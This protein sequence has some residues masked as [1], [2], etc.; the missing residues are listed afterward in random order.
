MKYVLG[1]LLAVPVLFSSCSAWLDQVPENDIETIESIFETREQAHHWLY[2]VY[3]QIPLM[4]AFGGNP[5]FY[6]ADEFVM[7]TV[8][9]DDAVEGES[10]Y[11]GQKIAEGLQM[12]QDPYGDCW[13]EGS[14]SYCSLYEDIRNC[15]TFIENID[16]VYNMDEVEKLQWKGEIQALKAYCYFELMRRYGPIVLYPENIS[17]DA[18]ESEIYQ[19]RSHVD[20]CFKAIVDLLDEAAEHLLPSDARSF[21]RSA[22]F[23]KDAALA[24]KARVL[25]YAAS[26]LFNGNPDY[27]DFTGKDGE[28]LF[29]TEYDPEK[30]RLAAEAADAAVAFA[31]EHGHELFSGSA[32]QGSELQNTMR[33]I[34]YS[35][36]SVFDNPEFIL[37]WK[38]QA[39]FAFFL[40][41]LP[42]NQDHY[43][44][45][46]NGSINPSMKMVEMYYT[47][48]GLPI[49]AD[50][51]WN[52]R[53]RYKYNGI[54]ETN[55]KYNE[56][57]PLHTDVLQL[58][59]QREP[60][61]YACIAAD[62]TYWKRGPKGGTVDNNLLVEAHKDEDFGTS[63]DVISSNSYQNVNGY[64]LKKHTYSDLQTR[65]YN[66][67]MDETFPVIRLA[68]LYLIQAEAWNEYE[69]PSDK[70]Y[71][72]LNKVRERAGIPDVQTSWRSYS[73]QPSK[74]DSKEGMRDII[75][76]E[77]NIEFAFEGHRFFNL[78]R[79]KTAH[80]ELNYRPMGWNI[81]GEDWDTFYNR[82]QGPIPVE[83]ERKFTAPRD[84][85]FPLR[86]EEIL[87]SGMVQNP[88][89]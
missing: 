32:G 4:V 74:V 5:A 50:N 61:F 24:L 40:P 82:G 2:G 48:N 54:R 21:D 75:R 41:L 72:P 25:L 79:W 52:Y 20:T 58:H 60:R 66:I 14:G 83:T 71:D 33:D 9:R 8:V 29:S 27:S 22:Y 15:N 76:Q 42:D 73:N 65:S 62:R 17:V 7:A 55:T 26:P 37:E 18:D 51:T 47:A 6:G 1:L 56:V 11:P 89:W 44:G 68:E 23:S 81:L 3:S 77:I 12:S 78:R 80:E 84:Y 86:A 28:P 16:N 39:P 36:H 59:L 43:S 53:D 46:L 69:G 49:D 57:V 85:L 19:S 10:R 30:W 67:G 45:T 87:I 38:C 88:G 63:E 64:W 34:E 70:V 35:V 31:E 13:F